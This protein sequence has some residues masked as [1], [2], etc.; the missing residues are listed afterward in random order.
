MDFETLMFEIKKRK[1]GLLFWTA[2]FVFMLFIYIFI[3]SKEFSFL[4]ILSSITQMLGFLIVVWKLYY[5]KSSSGISLNTVVS[6]L[7]I[8]SSRLLSTIFY[9]GYLPS[10]EAGDWFYQ[11]TEIITL[12][13]LIILVIMINNSYRDTYNIEFDTIYWGYLAIPC[14]GLALLIHTNLNK[15]VLTDASWTF[16]MY[17]ETVAIYPQIDLFVKKKGQIESF[18]GHYVALQ[19]LSRL[20]SLIFWWYTY[21]ELVSATSDSGYSLFPQYCGYLIIL[22][23]VAQL[24]IMIDYYYHY[25]KGIIK[26][27]NVDLGGI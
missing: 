22:S 5:Y 2:G 25:F 17:L 4:I 26:G 7:V 24:I 10:D 16:S 13:C 1:G 20:F 23:Q 14:L 15:N 8:I 3:S 18:T 21:E 12:V 19:G 11:L 27:E 6:Y 9:S